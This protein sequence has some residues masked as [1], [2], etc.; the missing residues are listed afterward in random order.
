MLGAIPLILPVPT[1]A[2]VQSIA[3]EE[4]AAHLLEKAEADP[5]GRAPD[6]AGPEVLTLAEM[7]RSWKEAR[8]ERR[9]IVRLPIPGETARGFREG[10]A[11]APDRA[12]GSET[13]GEWLKRTYGQRERAETRAV[14]EALGTRRRGE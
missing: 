7:A 6:I 5:A 11:T 2:R 1:R 14:Q 8:D 10:R 9:W 12:V 13:W 3:A 4:A